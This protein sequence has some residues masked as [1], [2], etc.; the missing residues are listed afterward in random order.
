[1][2]NISLAERRAAAKAFWGV[3]P[4]GWLGYIKQYLVHRRHF[5]SICAMPGSVGAFPGCPRS[6]G[7]LHNVSVP[8]LLPPNYLHFS[9]GKR[10]ESAKYCY[11]LASLTETQSAFPQDLIR[12]CEI[13]NRC[14]AS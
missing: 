14:M 3:D 13:N 4:S 6:I 2:L 8:P 12:A 5:A 9:D 10:F 11:F 1:M 7:D